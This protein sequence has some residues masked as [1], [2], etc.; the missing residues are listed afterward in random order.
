MNTELF[1]VQITNGSVFKWSNYVLSYL[2]DHNH[3]T[4]T[5][6]K[7]SDSM[8]EWGSSKS[9]SVGKQSTVNNSQSKEDLDKEIKLK[10]LKI[11]LSAL[12]VKGGGIG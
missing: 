10:N 1:E 8:G 5:T 12:K 3:N 4:T 7:K 9:E 2:Q 11:I 6:T